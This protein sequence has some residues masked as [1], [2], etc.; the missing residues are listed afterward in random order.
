MIPWSLFVSSGEIDTI[1]TISNSVGVDICLVLAVKIANPL[2][3]QRPPDPQR[4][5]WQYCTLCDPLNS[6]GNAGSRYRNIEKPDRAAE[7]RPDERRLASS[8][9]LIDQA[10]LASDTCSHVFSATEMPTIGPADD[11]SRRISV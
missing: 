3:T 2:V 11:V 1:H 8:S 7:T 9:R 6:W 4:T 10:T 5:E